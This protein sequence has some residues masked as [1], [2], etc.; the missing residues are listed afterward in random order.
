MFHPI[1]VASPVWCQAIYKVPAAGWLQI[2]ALAGA[3]EAGDLVRPSTKPRMK[4]LVTNNLDIDSY[5]D[6]SKPYPPGEHQNS[7]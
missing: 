6:G 2:F 4:E 1:F 3:I 5:G 7:F